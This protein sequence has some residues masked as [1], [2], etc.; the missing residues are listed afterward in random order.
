MKILSPLPLSYNE[1]KEGR[2]MED[3]YTINDL[4]LWLFNSGYENI[5]FEF[6]EWEEDPEHSNINDI[7]LFMFNDGYESEWFE[8]ESDVKEDDE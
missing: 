2:K 6:E 4:H 8:F 1:K 5:W 7:H 3:E